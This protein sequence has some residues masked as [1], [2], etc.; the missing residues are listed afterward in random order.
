MTELHLPLR[1]EVQ[2][3]RA[4]ARVA[5]AAAASQP[6][7]VGAAD[8]EREGMHGIQPRADDVYA[9]GPTYWLLPEELMMPQEGP[10]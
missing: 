5:R 1:G 3:R 10:D 4:G 8:D 2:A 6:G 9:I 7:R